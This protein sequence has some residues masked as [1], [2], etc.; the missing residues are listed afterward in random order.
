M[1]VQKPW[2]NKFVKI[3]STQSE[4]QC[5][6]DAFFITTLQMWTS[7]SYKIN[8]NNRRRVS[9]DNV[10]SQRGETRTKRGNLPPTQQYG[11]LT[12]NLVRNGFLTFSR[13]KEVP[14]LPIIERRRVFSEDPIVGRRF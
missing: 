5:C 8:I 6:L 4:I 7:Q 11:H 3:L 12:L 2:V 10:K 13:D 14:L 1:I 9:K